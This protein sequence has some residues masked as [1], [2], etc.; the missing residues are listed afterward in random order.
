M[1][2][3]VREWFPEGHPALFVV[4][5]VESLDLSVFVAASR[6]TR[7]RGRPAYH[8]TVMVGIAMYASMTSTMSSR[9]IERPWRPMSGSGSWPATNDLIT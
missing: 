3:D 4:E 9:R 1:P 5:V 8:P 7:D 2:P 6:T